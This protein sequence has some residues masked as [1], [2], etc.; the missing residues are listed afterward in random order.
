MVEATI[1]WS[2]SFCLCPFCSIPRHIPSSIFSFFLLFTFC[3]FSIPIVTFPF[4]ILFNS[5]SYSFSVSFSSYHTT[6][7]L[8]YKTYGWKI[9][10]KTSPSFFHIFSQENSNSN[11]TIWKRNFMIDMQNNFFRYFFLAKQ[12]CLFSWNWLGQGSLFNVNMVWTECRSLNSILIL[13]VKMVLIRVFTNT[14][15]TL[16]N[17]QISSINIYFKR[18]LFLMLQIRFQDTVFNDQFSKDV[19]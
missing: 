7:H 16:N 9:N 6:N 4:M 12:L 13:I 5:F 14:A 17:K 1:V 8:T 11:W 15:I 3:S 10:M 18:Y 19:F 2:S